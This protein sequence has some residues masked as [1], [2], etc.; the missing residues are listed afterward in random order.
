MSLSQRSAAI[1]LCVL[2]CVFPI[3]A[4]QMCTFYTCEVLLCPSLINWFRQ[5]PA[6]L[7]QWQR[8]VAAAAPCC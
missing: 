2:T 5:L 1:K 3:I 8:P 6:L 7:H 4:A